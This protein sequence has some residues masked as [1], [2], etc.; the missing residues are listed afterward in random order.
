MA[1]LAAV[2][3]VAFFAVSAGAIRVAGIALLGPDSLAVLVAY[4]LGIVSPAI[5]T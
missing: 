3:L 5:I 2:R 1:G 4:A